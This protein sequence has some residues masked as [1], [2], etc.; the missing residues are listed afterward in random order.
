MLLRFGICNHL[1]IRDSHEL[2]FVASSLKDP[3]DA[4]IH[5]EAAPDGELLPA[6]LIF[7]ANASG[8]SNLVDAV[9]TMRHMVLHSHSAGQPGGGIARRPFML[10]TPSL[11]APS[12]FEL[13][14]V[15]DGVRHHYGFEATDTAYVSEWLYVFPKSQRRTLFKRDRDKFAFGRALKGPNATIAKLTRPNS[16]FVSAAAQNDHK[17]LSRVFSYFRSIQPIRGVAVYGHAATL[18]LADEALDQR[19]IDFLESLGTGVIGY[20]RSEKEISKI[21]R[22][23]RRDVIATVAK[24]IDAPA[25]VVFDEDL[26]NVKIELAH[27]AESGARVYFELERESAG[28]RRLLVLLSRTFSALDR[29]L[30]LVIDE[31]DASL[32]TQACEAVLQ[33][34]C[35]PDTNPKGAQLIATSH[36]TDLMKSSALR[37]D[38]IWFT[39]KDDTGAT[40]LYPLTDFSTRKGDKIKRGYLQGRFGAVPFQDPLS[41]LG[42]TN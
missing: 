16:L 35:S 26:T 3:S 25:Q 23:L 24:A 41:T 11:E 39:C 30:P 42:P 14:F 13:D 17:L 9:E 21:E 7:G 38:E 33:L 2:S 18:Q 27:R 12:R 5:C 4:L 22:A 34:F 29:G 15:I 28:T 1:S 37:R 19:V 31:F 10:H 6:A 40:E 36:N 32:H 20:R 8:K